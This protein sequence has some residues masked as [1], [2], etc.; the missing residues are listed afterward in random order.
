[1]KKEIS[2]LIIT[3]V[4]ISPLTATTGAFLYTA[5]TCSAVYSDTYELMIITSRQFSVLLQPFV[6]HKNTLGV[7][8]IVKNI[9]DIYQDYSG[10]DQAEQIK[11]CIQDFIESY[12]TRFVLF[13]GGTKV[14]PSRYT[15]IYFS[16]DF[17]Y[18]TPAHWVFASD[19]YYADI[20]DADGLFS[21]W[22]TNNNSVFAEYA[23]NGNN[24]TV[25]FTPDV[26][27]G[28]LP[29]NDATEVNIVMQ[30]IM[31]YEA[32]QAW[33]QEWFSR[34]ICVGGDSLPGDDENIDEGEYVQQQVIDLLQGF[35]P[36]RIWASNGML[37]SASLINEAI[38]NGAGFVFFNG[39]GMN[40]LWATHP[41]NS[42]VWIPPG[43]YTLEDINALNNGDKLPIVISDACYHCQYD[44]RDDC[45]G[46]SFVRNPQ[47][48]AIAFIGGSDTDLG[49]PGT[50]IIQKGIERLC[51]EIGVEYMN[52]CSFLGSLIGN[53]IRHYTEDE[54]NEV[55][56]ITVLQNHLFG[57]PSLRISG[58]SQSPFIP[59][60]P[61]GTSSGEIH[62]NYSYASRTIDPDD[63]DLYYMWDWGDG[64][65]FTWEGPYPSRQNVTASHV[66][67]VKGTYTIRVRAMDTTGSVSG[68]SDPLPITMPFSYNPLHPFFDWLFE[69]FSLLFLFLQLHGRICN[70]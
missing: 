7:N 25:D 55:D 1:M 28:R 2:V 33:S 53:A 30:K 24:D 13:V 69:R 35:T 67:T 6:E 11:Y 38:D 5:T 62:V 60:P 41:H 34:L 64:T 19:F 40:D 36:Q 59:D 12:Q 44:V 29:C 52:N 54:M 14:V 42:I 16:G 31:T 3:L 26:Y 45:F 43:F 49:Y 66:W 8:T 17:G 32:S 61:T 68:W 27:V 18:P 10:R 9:E 46:W 37:L 57:D 51:V 56:M 4:I 21:S 39:H 20:Y 50:A 58:R 22:D 23:W 70:N 63:D 47:G 48:G 65:M 15:H